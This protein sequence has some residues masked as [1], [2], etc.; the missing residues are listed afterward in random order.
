MR[1]PR[2]Q[3]KGQRR[4]NTGLYDSHIATETLKPERQIIRISLFLLKTVN[5]TVL[6][7]SSD[8]NEQSLLVIIAGSP[9]GLLS[10]RTGE[11]VLR[12]QETAPGPT[13]L[14]V[15]D[16]A[17]DRTRGSGLIRRRYPEWTVI[18]AACAQD[19]LN[20]LAER[21]VDAVVSD[22][23]MPN[24]DGRD[25]LRRINLEFAGLPVV[26]ITGIG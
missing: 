10:H 22:L 13:I 18:E 26:L 4:H 19:G 12:G 11:Q 9:T 8:L 14:F 25:F 7:R 15:D 20:V 2:G 6:V 1:T 5:T 17:T 16:S 23:V 21:H 24:M 3:Q